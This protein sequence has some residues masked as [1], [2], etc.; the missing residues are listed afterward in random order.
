MAENI[1][2]YILNLKGNL[3]SKLKQIGINSEY[4]IGVWAK[5]Q[6]KMVS[7]DKTMGEMGRTIGALNS[8]ISALRAQKEWIPTSNTEAIRKTNLE[9]KA[10]EKEIRELDALNGG[11]VSGWFEQLKSSIPALNA[12]TNP[13]VLIGAA[14]HKLSG[15]LGG[16][17]Q[18]YEQQS[19]AESKLAAVMRNTMDARGEEVKS[20]LE[21]A[22]AQQKLGVIGNEVQIAG[23]Q[24]LST[25]LT[26]TEL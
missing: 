4:Q 24:E 26:K 25:Y 16:A 19:E 6:T 1:A 14:T 7:A 17:K 23:A 11:K 21:V 15:Y 13:L 3:D 18:A 12:L 2:T 9:I 5:V 10:L 22:A 8:R 20:I